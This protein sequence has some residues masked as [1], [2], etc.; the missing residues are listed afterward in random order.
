MAFFRKKDNKTINKINLESNEPSNIKGDSIT[1]NHESE[2]K[3]HI[4][5]EISILKDNIEYVAATSSDINSSINQ[6]SAGNISQSNDLAKASDILS[7][8]NKDMEELAVNVVNV[9]I[10]VMDSDKNADDGL[11]TI[12]TLDSSLGDLEDALSISNSTVNDLVGKLE[13]VNTITDSISQIASQTNL[14]ALNAAIEAARAGDA[15]K[16]FSVVAGEVRK[17][18]ENSKIAVQNITK[19]LEEIKVDIL[20][21]SSAMSSGNNALFSQKSTIKQTKD[22]FLTIKSE[23]NESVN[24]IEKCIVNLTNSSEKKDIIISSIDDIS[25]LSEENSSLSEEIVATMQSQD[26]T[27]QSINEG[28]I[29]IENSFKE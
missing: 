18:A 9:Q 22:T 20:N 14:L 13:S 19:I 7:D 11:E 10:K 5:K 16:G 2:N 3:V 26:S 8:F 4:A 29:N 23:L 21:T 17:L 25:S 15:G 1:Q 24:E 12:K 28:I 27:I 6:M